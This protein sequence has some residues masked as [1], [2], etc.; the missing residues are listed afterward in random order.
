M[1][2][3]LI[4]AGIVCVGIPGLARSAVSDHGSS[5]VSAKDFTREG[6]IDAIRLFTVRL[7]VSLL[8][9]IDAIP[10]F[11]RD[12]GGAGSFDSRVMMDALIDGVGED[13]GD[14]MNGK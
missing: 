7:F 2:A 9:L 8:D 6:V 1:R 4:G 14:G 11:L 10:K 12:D 5:A 13:L 3:L